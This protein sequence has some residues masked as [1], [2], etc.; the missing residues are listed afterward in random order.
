MIILCNSL[1][2]MT[3]DPPIEI[4]QVVTLKYGKSGYTCVMEQPFKIHLFLRKQEKC[5]NEYL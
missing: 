4:A 2:G 3:S 5:S 1:A